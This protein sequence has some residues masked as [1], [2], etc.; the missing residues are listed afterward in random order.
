MERAFS[1]YQKEEEEEENATNEFT[2][3][4]GFML[5]HLET[6][7]GFLSFILM[8]HHRYLSAF[9]QSKNFFHTYLMLIHVKPF[10]VLFQKQNCANCLVSQWDH[11]GKRG[12]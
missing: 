10:E 9:I 1:L 6:S 11:I 12:T 7:S 5:L 8:L 3:G 2:K 4:G